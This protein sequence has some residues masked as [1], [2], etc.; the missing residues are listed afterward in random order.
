MVQRILIENKKL[1]TNKN[2]LESC[3]NNVLLICEDEYVLEHFLQEIINNISNLTKL[4]Y[5]EKTSD[6]KETVLSIFYRII[7]EKKDIPNFIIN[8]FK[9]IPTIFE[10]NKNSFNNLFQIINQILIYGKKYIE[11]NLN[12]LETVNIF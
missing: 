9:M 6:S 12:D 11:T 1:Y 10:N 3:L 7:E 4:L 5:N 8:D 2:I